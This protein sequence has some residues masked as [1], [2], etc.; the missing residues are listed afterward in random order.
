MYKLF[1]WIFQNFDSWSSST[2]MGSLLTQLKTKLST[3]STPM[4]RPY[5][6]LSKEA[7]L[8][9][10]IL[11]SV[12]Q[13]R[14]SKMDHGQ[15][16]T[17]LIE[18]DVCL[19]WLIS[20]RNMQVNSLLLR[21]SIMVSQFRSPRLQISPSLIDAIDIMEDGLIKSGG[22]PLPWMGHST[23]PLEENQSE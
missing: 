23:S 10:L 15:E 2:S 21:P 20:L 6:P 11:L 5:W 1:K 4:M 7:L 12:L 18:P 22:T 13:D 19:D 9:I 16:W 14:P 17:Q 3:S 8:K